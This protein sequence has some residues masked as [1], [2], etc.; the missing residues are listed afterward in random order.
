VDREK[1]HAN[2][3]LMLIKHIPKIVERGGSPEAHRPLSALER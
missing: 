1:A 3:A 2:A